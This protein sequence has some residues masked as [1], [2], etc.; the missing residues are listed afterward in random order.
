VFDVG[1]SSM[2]AV[3]GPHPQDPKPR[4]AIQPRGGGSKLF[5]RIAFD[6]EEGA[7][8]RKRKGQNERKKTAKNYIKESRTPTTPPVPHIPSPPNHQLF[9]GK[10]QIL[11]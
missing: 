9:F 7:M 3:F 6:D 10:G 1:A 2:V 11:M 5:C 8:R 4:A